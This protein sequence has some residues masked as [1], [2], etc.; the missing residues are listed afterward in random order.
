MLFLSSGVPEG[1]IPYL[2]CCKPLCHR[3]RMQTAWQCAMHSVELLHL[4]ETNMPTCFT[5]CWFCKDYLL[6]FRF[7]LFVIMNH[8]TVSN[9]Q[10]CVM[11]SS[12][13]RLC[14]NALSQSFLTIHLDG[15]QNKELN[16]IF[17]ILRLRLSFLICALPGCLC[18]GSVWTVCLVWEGPS[19]FWLRLQSEAQIYCQLGAWFPGPLRAL[20]LLDPAVPQ[21]CWALACAWWKTHPAKSWH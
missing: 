11:L 7:F 18:L 12:C 4:M 21:P 5:K 19:L 14:R 10:F 20:G 1:R 8:Y 13:R 16:S 17:Y 6:F 9:V 3:K 15:I 2:L